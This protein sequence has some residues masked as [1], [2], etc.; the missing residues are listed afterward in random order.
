LIR[1]INLPQ[2]PGVRNDN[3]VYAGF[4]VPLEYDPMLS[5]LIAHGSTREE[6]I[7]RMWRA[8][9]EYR[10]EGIR[11]TVP[12]YLYLIGHP[13]FRAARFD[14]GFIDGLLPGLELD[15]ADSSHIDA[16]VVAS[17]ILAF[18][19]SQNVQLPEDSQSAW[20]R[21]SRLES[22]GREGR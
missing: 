3:G 18:E 22:T 19:E 12:F 8:L 4:R 14:T 7:A 2:G 17:A 6:A 20:R 21:A 11:T 16:A 5:K 9:S 15:R 10:V 13:E 1:Y